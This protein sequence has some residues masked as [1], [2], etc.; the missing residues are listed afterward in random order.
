M[1]NIAIVEDDLQ[2]KNELIA[3]YSKF[4][5]Q[6][7]FEIN[8]DAFSTGEQLLFARHQKYDLISLDIDLPLMNGLELAKKIREKNSE[9]LII[10][11]TN[12]A[13]MAIHGYEVQAFDFI[14]KPLHYYS[15]ELKLTTA[16]KKISNTQDYYIYVRYQSDL[17]RIKSSDLLYAEIQDHY[18]Y[19]HLATGEKIN[20]KA[21]IKE[22]EEQLKHLPFSRCNNSYLINLKFVESVVKD[23]VKVGKDWI[24]ISRGRK[25]IFLQDL[26]NYM[27]GIKS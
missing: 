21:T 24:K 8:I 26:A 20:Q 22:L 1:I 6:H 13:Q 11:V 17:Y 10:F 2:T 16:F 19:Y 27:G 7:Q 15:F 18:L 5:S 4:A 23:E 25:K 12:L 3:Y 9:V 14:V